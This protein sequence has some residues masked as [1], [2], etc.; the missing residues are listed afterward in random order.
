AWLARRPL[1]ARA[2]RDPHLVLIGELPNQRVDDRPV[3]LARVGLHL[4]PVHVHTHESGPEA[5]ARRDEL[6]RFSEQP[7]AHAAR[8]PQP[9]IRNTKR[10]CKHEAPPLT[11]R[12]LLRHTRIVYHITS[13]ASGRSGET[14]PRLP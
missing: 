10:F 9:N 4:T 11:I 7:V 14:S 12:Q 13:H 3:P 8:D 5:A 2:N 6:V 1:R